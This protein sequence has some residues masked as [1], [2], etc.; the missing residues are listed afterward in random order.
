[1]IRLAGTRLIAGVLVGADK[2]DESLG[3]AYVPETHDEGGNAEEDLSSDAER[4]FVSVEDGPGAV[5]RDR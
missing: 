2:T 1:M 4:F 3:L 5:S